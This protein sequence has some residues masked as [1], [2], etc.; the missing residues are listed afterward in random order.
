MFSPRETH[1]SDLLPAYALNSLDTD[2]A[3]Q[4]VKHLQT[5]DEC[6]VEYLAY[7]AV[8]D[9]LGHAAP[10]MR[11]SPT[12]QGRLTSRIRTKHS[13]F[14]EAEP[15]IPY[16]KR[17]LSARISPAWLAAGALILVLAVSNLWLLQE[18][19]KVAGAAVILG[20][21]PAL[22]DQTLRAIP[23]KNTAAAPGARG[24]LVVSADGKRG[25]LIV[26]GLPGL[27]D[28]QVFQAWL[29][30][31]Q[32]PN[33]AGLLNVTDTGYGW[34]EVSALDRP[35]HEYPY[36]GVTVEPAGGSLSPT[37]DSVLTAYH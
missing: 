24:L 10:E 32:E 29:G 3:R 15:G 28:Q 11:P 20:S 1:I 8:V 4:V 34:I 14:A 21:S 27:T 2:E 16:W 37:G 30:E 5:C 31:L 26:D 33:S 25:M 12:L 19:N 18:V 13:P 6:Y 35:L 17:L 23:L 9:R 36:F 7:Q 22:G